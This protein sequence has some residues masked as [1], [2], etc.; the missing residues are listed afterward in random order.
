M[1]KCLWGWAMKNDSKDAQVLSN[2]IF[3]ILIDSVNFTSEKFRIF[4]KQLQRTSIKNITVYTLQANI[5]AEQF[6][7]SI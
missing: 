1:Y 5:H 7:K 3:R 2:E 6:V 4:G